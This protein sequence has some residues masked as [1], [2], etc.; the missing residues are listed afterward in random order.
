[1]DRLEGEDS[2][3]WAGEY[4]DQYVKDVPLGKVLE[5]D[6]ILAYEMNGAPLSAEHGYPIRAL[7]PGFYGTNSVKWLRRVTL[8]PRRSESLFTMKYYNREVRIKNETAI[9]PVW[10]LE[11]KSLIVRPAKGSILKRGSWLVTGWAWAATQVYV[12]EVSSDGG[13]TWQRAMLEQAGADHAWQQ[14]AYLWK[15]TNVGQYRLMSRATDACGQAQ[16]ISS[17]GNRVEPVDVSI[18]E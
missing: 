18:V 11:V 9:E 12:V 14:F 1:M 13:A 10:E 3:L 16:P 4:R 15:P 6:C 8:A 7:I 5:D 17:G 2:G